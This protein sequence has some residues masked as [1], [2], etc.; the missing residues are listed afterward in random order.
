MCVRLYVCELQ[1]EKK[2]ENFTFESRGQLSVMV[3][4]KVVGGGG[5][6]QERCDDFV[7]F[8]FGLLF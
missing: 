6:Q 8:H 1:R 5:D 7:S 4:N 2:R 3:T